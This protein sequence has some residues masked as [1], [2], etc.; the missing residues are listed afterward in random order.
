MFRMCSQDWVR[1]RFAFDMSNE[2]CNE[3]FVTPFYGSQFRV[4]HSHTI[5]CRWASRK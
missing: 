1:I 4:F 5:R 3:E 2:L